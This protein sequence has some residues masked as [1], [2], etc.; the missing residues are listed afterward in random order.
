MRS[1]SSLL[2]LVCLVSYDTTVLW[3]ASFECF[4]ETALHHKGG[5]LLHR[6]KLRLKGLPHTSCL[7]ADG[8]V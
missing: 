6:N 1:C 2:R 4:E 3:L 8:Y 7:S 5:I